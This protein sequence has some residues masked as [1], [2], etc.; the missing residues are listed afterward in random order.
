MNTN[1]LSKSIEDARLAAAEDDFERRSEQ[2]SGLEQM[3]REAGYYSYH[4]P[5]DSE[6]A[7]NEPCENCGATPNYIGMK[8]G[9]SYIA[10]CHCN[11]CGLEF[12][13]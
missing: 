1:D 8:K 13:F 10:I 12:E 3:Y 2:V 9:D 4:N 7:S 11:K 6:I 5:I